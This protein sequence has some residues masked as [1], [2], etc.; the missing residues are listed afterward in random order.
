MAISSDSARDRQVRRTI[1]PVRL[2]SGGR[3]QLGWPKRGELMG[4][5]N[6]SSMLENYTVP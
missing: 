6:A 1:T 5:Q 3:V 2:G 4:E